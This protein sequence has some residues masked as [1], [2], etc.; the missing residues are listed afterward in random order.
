MVDERQRL[1]RVA[2]VLYLMLFVLG[3]FVFLYGK[4]GALVPGDAAASAVNVRALETDFR[5]GLVIESVIVLIEIVLA[6]ILYVIFRPVHQALSA[7]AAFARLGEAI[8]QGG[9]LLT[10]W[11]ALSVALGGTGLAAFT[12]AQQEA[13]SL[14]LLEAN[15]F[16]VLV[17]GIFFGIHLVLLGWLVWASRLL[18]RWIGVLVIVAGLGYLAQS[19]GFI[20]W[21]HLKAALETAV[22]V[23][24]VPGELAL[25]GWLLVKG[26][27]PATPSRR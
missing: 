26:V 5:A 8:V 19:W 14:L 24:A 15:A 10:S 16:V 3:P 22:V 25:A 7:A 21:P 20:M 9:N 1:A 23:M 13:M 6:S 18:P 27:G 4:A 2:G 12:V 17:W 11:L